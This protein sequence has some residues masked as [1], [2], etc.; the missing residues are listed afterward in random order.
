MRVKTD[1]EWIDALNQTGVDNAAAALWGPVFAEFVVPDVFSEGD[2]DILDFTPQIL[3]ETTMLTTLQ[4]NLNYS[5]KG[6]LATFGR[7][8]ISEMDARRLGRIDGQRAADRRAI[9]NLIYGGE[10]GAEQLGNTEPNDGWNFRG[11][12]AI[13]IT[14][15]RNIALLAA[16]LGW[17]GTLEELASALR[18]QP[19]L[20][21]R[22]SIMWWEANID[23]AL[24]GNQVQ[25]RRRVNGGKIGL[26][27]C[28]ELA[29]RF[30]EV[31]A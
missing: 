24:L 8:R 4:E 3:H 10:Y 15:R 22:V 5:V 30:R 21:M 13:M 17:S 28:I 26:E 31:A 19:E 25:I 2:D 11:A 16:K 7:H 23:D 9:A 18:T 29:Q 6:L 14:G 20:A 1:S 12:G 27:H